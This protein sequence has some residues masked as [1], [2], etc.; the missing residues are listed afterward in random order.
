MLK[1]V[2]LKSLFIKHIMNKWLCKC[3]NASQWSYNL[4]LLIKEHFLFI[5]CHHISVISREMIVKSH[6]VHKS[7]YNF[8]TKN[9]R[10]STLFDFVM[11]CEEQ[12]E[13]TTFKIKYMLSM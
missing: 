10:E 3:C 8:F 6:A 4:Q 5:F 11:K 12:F 9:E 13:K 1:P 2:Q 7:K